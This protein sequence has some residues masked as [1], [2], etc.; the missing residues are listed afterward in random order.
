[1]KRMI[2]EFILFYWMN[3]IREDWE[4]LTPMGRIYYATPWFIRS[5]IYWAICPIAIPE[6]LFKRSKAYERFILMTNG[7][8]SDKLPR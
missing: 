3:Y 6:F 7:I 8:K 2:A 4:L 5:V 1:M